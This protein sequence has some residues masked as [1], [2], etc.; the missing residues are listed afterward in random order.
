[1]GS[2]TADSPMTTREGVSAAR[3]GAAER[4]GERLSSRFHWRLGGRTLPLMGATCLACRQENRPGR[5]FCA[6]CGARLGLTCEACGTENEPGERFCGECGAAAASQPAAASSLRAL[7]APAP[8]PEGERKQLTVLFA[9]VQGS[10]NLQEDLDVEAWAKIVERFVGILVDE[11][12]RFGGTVDK[13]TGDGIMALFGAPEAQ[14]D[15]ARRAC[16]AAWQM[17]RAIRTYAEELR[18]SEGVDLRVRLGRTVS[19]TSREVERR[20]QHAVP[21]RVPHRRAASQ[22]HA[23]R[24]RGKRTRWRHRVR[25]NLPALNA[26]LPGVGLPPGSLM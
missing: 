4:P 22:Q 12:H 26:G 25:G 17:G 1:M 11:V 13:F 14:E 2:G 21:A 15:H 19:A 5:K 23:P 16:H 8:D 3:V 9:D 24:G 18:R 10:M 20:R 6:A 7:S